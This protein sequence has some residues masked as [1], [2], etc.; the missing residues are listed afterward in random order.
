MGK[1]EG[2]LVCQPG[3]PK[4]RVTKA[5][6]ECPLNGARLF[7]SKLLMH[8]YSRTARALNSPLNRGCAV[9][10]GSG[11]FAAWAEMPRI[12]PHRRSI[13]MRPQRLRSP[14]F[15]WRGASGAGLSKGAQ[16]GREPPVPLCLARG[17]REYWCTRRSSRGDETGGIFCVHTVP[18][19][20]V[21]VPRLG[22]GRS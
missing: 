1:S 6:D 14:L 10:F 3:T 20:G 16:P 22:E 12:G 7:G 13:A 21:G 4:G 11:G 5:P 15:T 17:R 19:V 2:G 9:W 18:E 8:V